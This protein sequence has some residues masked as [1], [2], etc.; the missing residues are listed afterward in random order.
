MPLPN[1]NCVWYVDCS[2]RRNVETSKNEVGYAVVSDH[3]IIEAA[4]LQNHLSAQFAELFAFSHELAAKDNTL[5][6]YT[7][8]RYT[9]AVQRDFGTL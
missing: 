7:D 6:V 5:T 4:S 2:V 3:D 9:F 1:S 8:S